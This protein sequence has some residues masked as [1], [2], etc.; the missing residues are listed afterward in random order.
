MG[1]FDDTPPHPVLERVTSERDL[2]MALRRLGLPGP[3]PV[4]VSVGGAGGMSRRHLDQMYGLV[5]DHVMP[6]LRTCGACV[7]DGGTRSGVMRVMG[8]VRRESGADIPLIG[9]AAEGTVVLPGQGPPA[10]RAEL[11]P[12]HTHVLLVP[13]SHWGDEAPWIS[14]T[15][16]AL[17]G[18]SGLGSVTLVVNGGQLTYRDVQHSLASRRPVIV[19]AGTGRTAD[20]I[21][22]AGSGAADDDRAADLASSDLVHVVS[23]HDG[24]AIAHLL[25]AFLRG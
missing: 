12:D 19:V 18:G 15:A 6:V 2:P 9:V 13:G 22:A 16:G 20:A 14:A 21:A 10:E 8:Q 23:L 11:D 24:P 25:A 1:E 7:V 17:T 4:L 5:L 3:R